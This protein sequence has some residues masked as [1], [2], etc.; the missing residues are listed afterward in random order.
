MDVRCQPWMDGRTC[1]FVSVEEVATCS[2]RLRLETPA[3]CQEAELE[4]LRKMLKAK[5]AMVE[6]NK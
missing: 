2:Y 1:R 3:A 5:E 4:K 6:A